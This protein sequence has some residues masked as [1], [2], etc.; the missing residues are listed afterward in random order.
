MRKLFFLFVFS[1]L[2]VSSA[3]AQSYALTAPDTLK[4]TGTQYLTWA[5]TS[6]GAFAQTNF[7]VTVSRVSGTL[8]GTCV[9]EVSESGVNWKTHPTADTLTL[10]NTA[11]YY[12]ILVAPIKDDPAFSKYRLK[13]T[14][15]GTMAAILKGR[16]SL[17][18]AK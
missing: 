15:S 14:G 17:L 18:A 8:A 1:I 10:S 4:N 12:N 2:A 13:C 16:L 9:L 7:E 6:T 5:G 3:N 11:T